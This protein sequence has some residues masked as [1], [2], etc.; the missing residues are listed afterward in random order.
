MLP[1]KCSLHV[2]HTL[3]RKHNLRDYDPDRW[4]QDGHIDPTRTQLNKVLT[5]ADYRQFIDDTFGEAVEAYNV[6]Q[7]PKHSERLI[8]FI[9][10]AD[11]DQCPVSE[12]RDRAVK[13][14]AAEHRKDVQEVIIQLGDHEG[15][16]QLV[17]SFGQ[18]KADEI[19]ADY[20]T[21]AYKKWLTDNPSL[22]VMSA[23][24]H[25]DETRGGTPHLHLDF[26]PVVES[27]KGL[28]VKVS[29]DG[30]MR[31]LGY[32]RKQSS[33]YAETPYKRWIRAT[34]AS[35]EDAA[36]LYS[37]RHKLGIVILPSEPSTA[38]H[39]QPQ[40]YKARQRRVE[41]S[42]GAISDLLGGKKRLKV[43]A[44]EYI[45][46]NADAAKEARQQELNNKITAAQ[47][48][49]SAHKQA[50]ELHKQAAARLNARTTEHETKIAEANEAIQETKALQANL[51]KQIA[52][53]VRRKIQTSETY[54]QNA[55]F[56]GRM[57]RRLR[58]MG[59][60]TNAD[61]IDKSVREH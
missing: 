3:S 22:R 24:I 45:I 59:V 9:N 34:R 19:Y 2:G 21:Q 36:Q 27:S 38:M 32:D 42:K 18:A 48:E 54:T 37:N 44:A 35:Y 40:A 14:Y 52:Q 7:R 49:A 1:Q 46:G 5:D 23:V 43:E 61:D 60:D 31:Q 50:A 57:E 25:M 16:T 56:S 39:E 15:Y 20:L 8:G 47:N 29:M 13:A 41:A 33:K 4:N 53:A 28:S 6:K 10:A 58:Q 26:M 11:Y 12:R 55:A 30:A 51:N 17:S